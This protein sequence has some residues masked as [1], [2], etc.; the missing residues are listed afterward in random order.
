[1]TECLSLQKYPPALN[2]IPSRS[3]FPLDLDRG[4]KGPASKAVSRP[5]Q[6]REALRRRRLNI[7][8]M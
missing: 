7:S 3:G 4:H 8:D 5:F 2:P 1:V 6:P